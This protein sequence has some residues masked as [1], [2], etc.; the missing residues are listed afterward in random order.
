MQS[1]ELQIVD[2][3]R[4][5]DG[6]KAQIFSSTP[7]LNTP[8]P[9]VVWRQVSGV[10]LSQINNTPAQVFRFQF[11]VYSKSLIQAKDISTDLFIL[12]QK[13][14]ARFSGQNVIEVV[15]DNGYITV[16]TDYIIHNLNHNQF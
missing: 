11:D 12:L 15:G 6:T 7:N 2:C 5:Y 10:P 3:L 9:Y 1:V 14:D 16:S 8:M 4:D 13:I